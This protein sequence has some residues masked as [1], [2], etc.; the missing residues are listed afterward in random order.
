MA[1]IAIPTFI[2]SRQNSKA[3]RTANDFRLFAEKFEI[4]NLGAG[5]WPEDG[6]PATVPSGMEELLLKGTWTKPSAIGGLWDYDF[7]AFGFTAGVSIH[8]AT[9]SNETILAVDRLLDDGNLSSGRLRDVGDNH[10]S[11]ILEE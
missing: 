6:Y 9:A 3:A 1:S 4:Y 5:E 11:F 7:N 10:I 8:G 2:Q